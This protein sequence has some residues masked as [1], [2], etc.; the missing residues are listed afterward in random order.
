MLREFFS[1]TVLL[2]LVGVSPLPAQEHLR[3]SLADIK[4]QDFERLTFSPL[5]LDDNSSVTLVSPAAYRSLSGELERALTDSHKSLVNVLGTAPSFTVAI[6]LMDEATFFRRTKAPRWTNAMFYRGEI[7]IPL[8][9]HGDLNRVALIR[10]AR[11]EYTH[12]LVYNLSAGR[13]PG[14]LD[15]GIAQ[16][17]EGP[18]NPLLRKALLN[19]LRQN[20]PVSFSNLQG[21]FTKLNTAMVPAAYAQSLFGA[22]ALLQTYGIKPVRR[23]F[24]RLRAGDD[25]DQAFRA[26]FG[27]TL[28]TY[29]ARI[30]KTLASWRSPNR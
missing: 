14:W 20:S 5:K 7:T 21:G 15:E 10:A 18:E 17:T 23:Y 27:V 22:K 29:E 4:A 19:W 2:L 12:A 9:S 24:E 25:N 6:R 28:R 1:A 11:H 8:P 3:A 13:C 30:E 26:T 16:W